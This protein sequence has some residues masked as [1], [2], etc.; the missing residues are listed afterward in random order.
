MSI[1]QLAVCALAACAFV[2]GAQA[3][4]VKIYGKIDTGIVYTHP[5][6][7]S[8]SSDSLK[9][10]SGPNSATRVGIEGS[11]K[12]NND[13]K[14]TFRL[15]SR[16]RSDDGSFMQ[17]SGD[18]PSRM[19]GGQSTL[20]LEGPY[21]HLSFGRVG[22]V[23][24]STGWYD[25][26][27]YYTDVFG[28]GTVGAGNAPVK[29]GRYDNMINYRT[30]MI[31]GFQGTFQYSLNNDT[32]DEGTEG[33]SDSNHYYS[34]A[35]RFNR[36]NLTVVGAYE[37]ISWGHN[38]AI[39][40]VDKGSNQE[41]K[42]ISLGGNYALGP[43]TLYLQG[44]YFDGVASVD[45]SFKTA[46][47]SGNIDGYGLYLGSE[48]W[49]ASSSLKTA[50]YWKDYSADFTDHADQDGQSLGL[51]FKYLYNFSK[52]YSVYVG[53]GVSKVSRNY[54]GTTVLDDVKTD[55]QYNLFVGM[56]KIF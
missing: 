45:S 56:T 40:R 29:S 46:N 36:G 30:P 12:L 4:D 52:T 49:F 13:Y 38:A 26:V 22:G 48:F 25:T 20:A 32:Y 54:S 5:F 41:Q 18:N 7:D 24:S 16:Y 14:V 42:V 34:A 11:E 31:A 55:K 10:E 8:L 53:G 51:A 3:A 37:G 9:M 27:M 17:F 35:V 28:G 21:G 50:L 23:G 43:A 2:A 19:F 15:E 44:Q 39:T 33:K 1:P 6:G 47:R